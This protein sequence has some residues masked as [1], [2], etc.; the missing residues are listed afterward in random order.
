MCFVLQVFLSHRR[1][2]ARGCHF[3]RG[4]QERG[5]Q[6]MWAIRP[7]ASLRHEKSRDEKRMRGQFQYPDFALLI[8]TDKLHRASLQQRY[9]RGI[10]A[11]ITVVLLDSVEPS[12]DLRDLRTGN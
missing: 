6:W 4:F 2:Y 8:R 3:N 1:G 9:N 12:V 10:D 7:G 11:E 5:N